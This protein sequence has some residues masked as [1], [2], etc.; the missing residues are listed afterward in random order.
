[1]PCLPGRHASCCRMLYG[2]DLPDAW[3][4]QLDS[5]VGEIPDFVGLELNC[6]TRIM[7][8]LAFYR[9]IPCLWL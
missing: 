5:L 4:L 3:G 2:K 9:G 8:V 6:A 7:P 1:M